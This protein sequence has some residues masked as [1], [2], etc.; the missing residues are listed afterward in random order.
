MK[1]ILLISCFLLAGFTGNL[2]DHVITWQGDTM[3]CRFPEK[4]SK[5]GLKPAWKYENGHI[6]LMTVFE[7]DSVR[8]LEAGQVKGYFR[9]K[10]GT[11][12]LCDGHFESM[13]MHWPGEDTSWYFMNL[14]TRGKHASLYRIWMLFNKHPRA[15]YFIRLKGEKI[16]FFTRYISKR[17]KLKELL[18]DEDTREGMMQLFEENKKVDYERAVK[19]YNQ[20]KDEAAAGTEK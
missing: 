7:N 16:P 2:Q 6:R 9:E 1:R 12:L 4:P 11:H 8:V 19:K 10:H 20:L 15:F 14:L 17:K 3:N 13:K 5:E 18:I